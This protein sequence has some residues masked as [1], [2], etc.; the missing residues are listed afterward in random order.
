MILVDWPITGELLHKLAEIDP[1]SITLV[2]RGS[3][4][5][6]ARTIDIYNAWEGEVEIEIPVPWKQASDGEK[7]I[8]AASA[9]DG[10]DST[11]Q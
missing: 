6:A 8:K 5:V 7:E 11:A 9:H 1:D 3:R 2:L 10:C 4:D